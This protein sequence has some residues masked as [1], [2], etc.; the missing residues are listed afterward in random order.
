MTTAE[1]VT[2]CKAL[3]DEGDAETVTEVMVGATVTV[4]VAEPYLVG[5]WVEVAVQVAVPA[6]VGVKTPEELIVP[7]V[8]VQVTPGTE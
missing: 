2:V 6:P 3:I 4:I 8:A 5:S 1:H 7:P